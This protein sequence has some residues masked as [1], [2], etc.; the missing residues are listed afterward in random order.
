VVQPPPVDTTPAPIY[1]S[2][3]TPLGTPIN[4]YGPY[5]RDMSNGGTAAGDGLKI[6]LNGVTYD[7]GLGV[8]APSTLVYSL[9]GQYQTF[10]TDMGLDDEVST[11]GTVYFQVYLDG[12]KVYDSGK[13]TGASATKSLKLDVS[14]KKQ[15]KLVVTDAG[16][17]GGSDH[18]DWE[19]ARL[20]PLAKPAAGTTS[21]LS[22]LTWASMTNGYGTAEKDKSNGGSA[23]GD[24]KTITLNGTTY[25]KGIGAHAASTILYD[26]AGRYSKFITDIGVDDEI[27]STKGSVVFQVWLDEVKVFDSGVMTGASVTK[28]LNL[29]V[30]GKRQL[31]L[32]VTDAGNGNGSD[33]ADWAGARLVS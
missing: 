2:D 24:G 27:I 1:L 18:A 16:D 21:Y 11:R 8:R 6:T 20:I 3:L 30:T 10:I 15:L 22:D 31:T 7:K 33:H 32:V 28:S 9:T 29:D 23:S 12:V 14:G 26:L 13:M 5:E 25:S 17:G 19:G 4:S